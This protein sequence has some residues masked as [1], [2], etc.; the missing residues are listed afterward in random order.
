MLTKLHV[1]NISFIKELSSFVFA[2]PNLNLFFRLIEEVTE[3][4]FIN[5]PIFDFIAPIFFI[6]DFPISTLNCMKIG[7]SIHDKCLVSCMK[8]KW[9]ECNSMIVIRL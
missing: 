9:L 5:H 4:I 8:A 2:S 6:A 1:F 3:F 7:R